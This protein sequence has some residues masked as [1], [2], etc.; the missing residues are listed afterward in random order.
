MPVRRSMQLKTGAPSQESH[1]EQWTDGARL[2]D[3][4]GRRDAVSFSDC[5]EA[6]RLLNSPE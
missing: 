2:L 5:V 3:A 1:V 6:A 4:V